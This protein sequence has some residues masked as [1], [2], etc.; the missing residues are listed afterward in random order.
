MEWAIQSSVLFEGA[1][2]HGAVAACASLPHTRQRMGGRMRGKGPA[3]RPE[4]FAS[5]DEEG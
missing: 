3:C 1:L 4:G 5:G 2:H